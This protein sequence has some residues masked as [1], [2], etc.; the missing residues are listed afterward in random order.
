MTLE[1]KLKVIDFNLYYGNFQA[2][3]NITLDI[4]ENRI[5]AIIGPSGCGKS[6]FVRSI[7][8]MND[9]IPSVR[10][11]GEMYMDEENLFDINVV[12]LR[13]R[14]GMVFQRPNPFPKSVYDNVAYGPRMHGIKNTSDLNDIVERSLRA[15]ALWDEV[16]DDLNKSGL[17]L[18]G[19]AQQRLCI[20]RA[21]AVE[22]EMILM[23]EPA[24]AL[25]PLATLHIEEL[26]QT[27]KENYTI[28]IVTHNMQQAARSSDFTAFFHMGEDR[29]GYLVEYGPTEEIFT[30][31]RQKLTEEYISGRFG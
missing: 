12:D 17:A 3:N 9:L 22:P 1:T 26:M 27:L 25:D 10:T 6:T 18:S 15:A 11:H 31:P 20:A 19:G 4:P 28:V 29:A 7:N 5:T 13:R 21:L 23:D 8:R 30:N 24:S 14:V 16:K 2:L